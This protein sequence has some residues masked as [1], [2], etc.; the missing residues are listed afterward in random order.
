[1]LGHSDISVTQRYAHLSA[2]HKN[3]LAQTA[4]GNMAEVMKPK[5]KPE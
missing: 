2:E 3:E 5:K 4:G 1:L